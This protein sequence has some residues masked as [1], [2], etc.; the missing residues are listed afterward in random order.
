MLAKDLETQLGSMHPSSYGWALL[1]AHRRDDDARDTLQQAYEKVFSGKVI[2]EGRSSL[3]TWFFGVIRLTA[4]EHHRF[5]MAPHREVAHA[6]QTEQ[7]ETP[8]PSESL[9]ERQRA[10]LIA[11]V[12]RELPERQRE[13]LHLVF[14]EGLTLKEAASVMDIALGSASQHYERAK[15]KMKQLLGE[16]GA[17]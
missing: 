5:R 6:Q 14:Y 12:L 10:K 9:A 17:S 2:F 15:V 1:C 4:L 8:T 7:D 3:R 16:R 11:D 13:V